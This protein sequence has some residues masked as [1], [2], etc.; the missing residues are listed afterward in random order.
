MMFEKSKHV[1]NCAKLRYP[2]TFVAVF[3]SI[4]IARWANLMVP[5]VSFSAGATQAIKSVWLS[6]PRESA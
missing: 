5:I 6:P 3:F 4:R 2:L 1:Q